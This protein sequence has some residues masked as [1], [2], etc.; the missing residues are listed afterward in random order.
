MKKTTPIPSDLAKLTSPQSLTLRLVDFTSR[1][2]LAYSPEEIIAA[3][4]ANLQGE[5]QTTLDELNFLL[6]QS[7]TERFRSPEGL[8]RLVFAE[9]AKDGGIPFYRVARMNP[10]ELEREAR[11]K[12]LTPIA[13][14][15]MIMDRVMKAFPNEA[16]LHNAVL[17]R[18]IYGVIIFLERQG[19]EDLERSDLEMA[20]VRGDEHLVDAFRA[21]T[22]AKIMAVISIEEL[23]KGPFQELGVAL[24]EGKFFAFLEAVARGFPRA[25]N[26]ENDDV[27]RSLQKP[28]LIK[29][30]L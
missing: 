4:P 25:L 20:R 5:A 11:G 15:E 26:H 8:R 17:G 29:A 1:A 30:S 21:A 12:I 16:R 27:R 14:I 10:Q 9:A 2:K 24:L 22:L 6:D 23:A 18:D 13:V 28:F 19:I 3:K 7:K